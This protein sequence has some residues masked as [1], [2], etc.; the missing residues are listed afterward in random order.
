MFRTI[1]A[2]AITCLIGSLTLAAEA[3]GIKV[4]LKDSKGN[5]VG[6]ATLSA[7]RSGG[8]NIALDLRSLP[9][10]EHAI[11]V[12]AVATCEAPFESAGPHF[13]PTAKKHGLQ[14]PDGP[15]AGDMNNFTVAD[16]GK[17]K[18]TLTNANVTL[19]AG[20]NSLYTNGGT[21]LVIHAAADDMKTD[22]GG[23]AGDRIACG[24]ISFRTP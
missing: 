3:D 6:T 7:A 9:A 8:V 24:T 21:A 10:G 20:A 12:H 18:T 15:H 1:S 4:E 2:V 19:A 13:N 5:A 23:A 17:A 22:P 11:H 14:N 16:S